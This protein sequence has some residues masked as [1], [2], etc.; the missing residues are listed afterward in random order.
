MNDND[1]DDDDDAKGKKKNNDDFTGMCF[2]T[3]NNN[4]DNDSDRDEVRPSYD[5]L[6]DG[7]IKLAIELK[8]GQKKLKE[9]NCLC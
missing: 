4:D 8:K 1:N 9:S 6:E 3:G 7:L 5:E 2:M